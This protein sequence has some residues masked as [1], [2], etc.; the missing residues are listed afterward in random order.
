MKRLLD[1][2]L[3]RLTN[4]LLDMSSISERAV[5]MAVEAYVKGLKVTSTVFQL[6]EELR[7]LQDEV[8]DLALELIARYQPVANDLRYIRS[9][10]EI[11][12]GFL[13][14]GR[15]AYDISQVLDMFGDLS[16]CDHKAVE[17]AGK[18][19]KEMIK[20]SII[21]FKNKDL[22]LANK[23]KEMDDEVDDAYVNF[24][25]KAIS[26]PLSDKRCDMAATLI[27]RYLERIADHATYICEAINYIIKGERT[28][29][30]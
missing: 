19:A 11:A 1:I 30:R 26:N 4:M 15:Y 22:T 3:E 18:K 17:E 28:S 14:F 29:R 25:S 27:L 9:C 12:Y 6:S 7:I 13:R 20:M 21:A 23:V 24:V 8:S 5:E 10:M 2:G 16:Q